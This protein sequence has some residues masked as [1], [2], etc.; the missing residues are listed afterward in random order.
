MRI[1]I[2]SILGASI[3]PAVTGIEHSAH[4]TVWKNYG[5]ESLCIGVA[6]GNMTPGTPLILWDCNGA[7]DQVW[8]FSP[9]VNSGT[10]MGNQFE[11]MWT[12]GSSAPTGL[13]T[14]TSSRCAAL[15]GGNSNDFT[16]MIVWNCNAVTLDQG[17]S[18]VYVGPDANG[19]S[20]YYLLNQKAYKTG[21]SG[22]HVISVS[23]KFLLKGVQL[24]MDPVD[25]RENRR[26]QVWCAY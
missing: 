5:N 13:P 6:A 1:L 24:S 21:Y 16:K 23:T 20:C 8:N 22:L 25:S 9:Y 4:A 14:D 26:D 17:W 18:A 2:L 11:Q 19:A 15:A 12:S 3:L 10:V 7:P